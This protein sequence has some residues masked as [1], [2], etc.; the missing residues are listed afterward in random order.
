MNARRVGFALVG[1]R[2]SV[3]A[4]AASGTAAGAHNNGV[5]D[6]W[7]GELDYLVGPLGG[8]CWIFGQRFES[9]YSYPAGSTRAAG[10]VAARTAPGVRHMSPCIE[11]R[12]HHDLP[13]VTVP[14]L[15]GPPRR[16]QRDALMR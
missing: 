3:S 14:M 8:S 2:L 10:R 7:V 12:L 15:F 9:V 11:R 4:L 6:G 5:T 13:S 16:R 1:A